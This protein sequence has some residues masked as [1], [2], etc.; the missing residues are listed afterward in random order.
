MANDG[1]RLLQLIDELHD[2]FDVFEA[3]LVLE[4]SAYFADIAP[5]DKDI[6]KAYQEGRVCLLVKHYFGEQAKQKCIQ[7]LRQYKRVDET[8]SG[9]FSAQFPGILFANNIDT[10]NRDV[11]AINLIKSEIQAC[12]QDV[13]RR[14]RGKT[15]ESYHAR[16]YRQKHEF[17][18]RHLPN[19]ISYQLYRHIDVVNAGGTDE[20]NRLKTVSFYWASKNADE[21]LSLDEAEHYVQNSEEM[22]VSPGE[23]KGIVQTLRD[24]N[25][26]HRF[27]LRK[28]RNDTINVSLYFGI[29][30]NGRPM[31]SR[32]VIQQPIIITGCDKLPKIG[33]VKHQDPDRR[34]EVR[35]GHHWTLL[36]PKLKLYRRP[37]TREE[38]RNDA[39]QALLDVDEPKI[40]AILDPPLIPGSG[41]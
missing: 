5:I 9:R 27:C 30:D 1:V 28:T 8:I 20:D 41:I 26:T 4:D 19:A 18:H 39:E 14:K 40:E 38:L 7:A 11:A 15:L 37:K 32:T 10:V 23:R 3:N 24:S 12:V 21:Y 31:T 17:L 29:G 13:R 33:L 16:N 2:A 35:K 36:N 34:S 22:T 25:L 6:Q